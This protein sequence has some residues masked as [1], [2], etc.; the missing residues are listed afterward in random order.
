MLKKGSTVTTSRDVSRAARTLKRA[1]QGALNASAINVMDLEAVPLRVAGF[2]TER[3]TYSGGSALRTTPGDTQSID[4]IF[5]DEN[6]AELSQAAQRKLERVFSRQEFRRAF[7]GEIAEL[8]YPPR[9]VDFYTHELLRTVDLEAARAAGL[10]VVAGCAGGTVS[11]V[12]PSPL[13]RIRV[14]PLTPTNR[15]HPSSPPPTAPPPPP[16]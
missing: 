6:G 9:V 1:V 13:A 12:L 10:K 7:P 11:L 4:I 16:P 3:S 14:G 5:L 15:P 8:S 2:E